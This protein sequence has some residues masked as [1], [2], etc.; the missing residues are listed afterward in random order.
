MSCKQACRKS[1]DL[2]T[3]AGNEHPNGR[4]R[5]SCARNG[6]Q[7]STT[8]SRPDMGYSP[9]KSKFGLD[10][11]A[12]R[13]WERVCREFPALVTTGTC[14]SGCPVPEMW[15]NSQQSPRR[16]AMG[17]SPFRAL[18]PI[19]RV[20]WPTPARCGYGGL[21]GAH[22]GSRPPPIW[23]ERECAVAVRDPRRL[24]RDAMLSWVV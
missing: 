19:A 21:S 4:L 20:P 14:Q 5:A 8:S 11:P 9:V 17:Y 1:P 13:V 6:N 18:R 12:K 15:I 22:T 24:Y 2:V 10:C 3:T 23:G 16:P 7:V